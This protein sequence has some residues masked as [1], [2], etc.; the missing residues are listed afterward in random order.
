MIRSAACFLLVLC[1][2]ATSYAQQSRIVGGSNVAEGTYPWMASVGTPSF[3]SN[4]IFFNQFC[5]GMLVSPDYVLTAGHCVV[6][7]NPNS[8]EVVVGVTNLSNVPST[9]RRRGVSQIILHPGFQDFGLVFNDVALL[10]LDSPIT[11]ITPIPIA[12]APTTSV[13]TPVKAIGW[14]DTTDSEFTTNF[15]QVLQQVDLSTVSQNRIRS[16]FGNSLSLQH[17]GAFAFGGDTCQGDSGGPL[18]IESPLT[19]VGITSF[20]FGCA[21]TTAGV[22]ANV[23]FYADFINSFIDVTPDT[24]DEILLGDV[25]LDEAVNFFDISPFIVVLSGAG[26]G[27]QEEADIDRNGSVN[28]L[29][30]APFID[31]LS[32]NTGK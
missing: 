21:D 1:L 8:L 23:G 12:T 22:Y 14:G 30:I 18:F 5:G 27:F 32:G 3:G 19:L 15:P 17:L 16:E 24:G 7:E 10:K 26:G 31:I 11:D 9:A 2:C 29:D 20:G 28:F 6:G 4:S 25:N 13:G